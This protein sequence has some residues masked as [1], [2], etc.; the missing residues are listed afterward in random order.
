MEFRKLISELIR[1]NVFKAVIAYLAVAWI[2]VQIASIVLPAF[3]APSYSLKV[4]I[5]LLAIGLVLWIIFSW[6]YDLT[7]DGF[8]RTDTIENSEE[9]TKLNSRRLNKIIAGSLFI[10]VIL[11]IGAS[12]WAGSK[13]NE[14]QSLSG[15]K[16]I[17]V[18]PFTSQTDKEED[19]VITG[20]TDA[21]IEELSKVDQLTVIS[22]ASSRILDL[23]L[24]TANMFVSSES[25]KIVHFVTGSLN[26]ELNELNIHLELKESP[27]S[28]PI[29]S[30]SYSGDFSNTKVILAEAS[31]DLSR[32]MGIIV[33]SETTKL[34]SHLRPV[35]PETYELYLKG[36][37]FLSKPTPQDWQRGLVYLEEARDKNPSDSYA[38]SGLA[39]GYIMLGHGPAPSQEVFPKAREAALRAIKLDSTNANGWA[40]LAHYHTYFGWDWDLAEFAFNKANELN[41]SLAYNHYH[42]AWYLALFGRMTEAIEEHKLAQELDPF[43]SLHSAWL[44]ELLQWVGRY[45]EGLEEAEK[46]LQ[47]NEN[48]VL[49]LLVKSRILI[50][51]G[52]IDEGLEIAKQCEDIN[53]FWGPVAYGMAHAQAGKINEVNAL[54]EKLSKPPVSVFH[55]YLIGLFYANTGETEKAI[56]WLSKEPKHAF[57]PWIRVQVHNKEL[58]QD[59]RFLELIREMDLPDPSPLVYNSE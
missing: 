36:K 46:A 24:S 28:E 35:R 15:T 16:K 54:I 56:E 7:A 21:L 31:E 43:T 19:Y 58:L 52:K 2:I 59:P 14:V 10:A 25:D 5:Y 11:L 26:L 17:A 38:N 48:D 30:K 37:H 6:I 4:V 33:T 42:R 39:E 27:E 32:Q 34:W 47:I 29:W 40:A 49:G 22:Q 9:V 57:Y 1:R 50:S 18:I 12:F 53:P 44:G 55:A 45:E 20:M 13:W 8:K 3:D 41:P 23:P 51:Q